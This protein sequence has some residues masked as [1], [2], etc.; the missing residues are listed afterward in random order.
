MIFL[1]RLINQTFLE[2]SDSVFAGSS[3]HFTLRS[4]FSFLVLRLVWLVVAAE[5]GVTFRYLVDVEFDIR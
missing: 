5:D 1:R 4:V 3:S 2:I